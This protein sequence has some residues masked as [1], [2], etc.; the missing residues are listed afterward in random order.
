M[1]FISTRGRAPE[2]G[3]TDALLAGLAPDGGLYAPTTWPTIAAEDIAGFSGR[4]YPAV[5]ADI[6]GRFAGEEIKAEDLHRIC[7]RA[8]ARFA[9]T[10]TAPLVQLAPDRFLLEL[11][12]GP[13]LAFKD[14]AMQV[15][16]GLFEHALKARRRGMTIVA[17]TSGDTG[18]A[19]AAAF[20]GLTGVRLLVLFPEGRVS[21]VQRRFMTTTGASNVRCLAVAGDFDDCQAILKGLFADAAFVRDTELA[22]VNS[23][24]F[25][26]I[27]A[28][29]VYFFTAAAALG[30]PARK[31]AFAVP[32]GNFG[33]AYAGWAAARMGLPIGRLIIATNANDIVAR[34][35]AHGDYRRGPA[36]ATQSP[37]MDIQAASNF[38]RL[39]FEY[40]GRGA[41][42]TAEAFA[43]FSRTGGLTLTPALREALA[44]LFVGVASSEA[45]TAAAMRRTWETAGRLID[46]HTAVAVAG[47]DQ[48]A[49]PPSSTPLVIL[50]TA[51]PAKFPEAV[52]AAT[53]Q[54]AHAPAA[55]RLEGL[56]ERY[57]RLP[58]DA[59]A[60][61][62]YVR[63]WG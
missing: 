61:K 42:E 8:Y 15:L 17:A 41:L 44:E 31:T 39:H 51:H 9:H 3:F 21:D 12:H 53:G 56:Q 10:A 50:A 62:T 63:A 23:I 28:Q 6:L 35:L 16:G 1:R 46:P 27:A 49:A 24:N 52:A 25:A 26:R 7:A 11:F 13:T 60:V 22:A 14:V 57:D 43:T 19:A 58:A 54:V 45:A 32:T 36:I 29:C 34:A 47:A 20:A 18:G 5:A 33:D 38:E 37:A 30:A 48:L 2:V 59:E 4:P 55:T 40:A